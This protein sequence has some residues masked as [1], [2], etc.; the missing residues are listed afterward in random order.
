MAI[1]VVVRFFLIKQIDLKG[2]NK[3]NF[4]LLNAALGS[5]TFVWGIGWF[6]F[7]DT[8]DPANYL[9]YQIISLTVLF[10]GMVGYCVSWKSFSFFVL[11]L[12]VPELIF[13]L[14]NY[15]FDFWPIPI[16]SMVAF[17]LAIKMALLFSKSWEKSYSLR[18][19]ND[20][21]IAQLVAEKNASIAANKAK[22]EFIATASHDLRQPMQSINI[23]IDMIEPQN[24]PESESRVFTRMK[25]SIS[26]LNKMFNTLLDISRLDSGLSVQANKNFSVAQLTHDLELGFAELCLEKNLVLVF[27][28]HDLIAT[29]DPQLVEQILRNLL[30]NAVQYTETGSIV[31]NFENDHG[32]LK[33]SVQDTGHGIPA[34][35]LPVIFN[36]FYRSEHSRSHHDGLGL[37]LSIV[38]RIVQKIGGKCHVI[39]TLGLGS[40]F[41]IHTQYPV[42]Q[43]V[44]PLHKE[45]HSSMTSTAHETENLDVAATDTGQ[46]NI[47]IIENDLSLQT[48]YEQYFTKAGYAVHLIPYEED[49]FN[50]YLAEIPNLHFILSD[51]RLGKHD[52]VFFIQK[53]REEFNEDIP[54]CIVTAD[55]SPQHLELF[56]QL[57]IHVLYKP[58]DIQK[59]EQYIASSLD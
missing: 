24:L 37:G 52:G 16:G 50:Q 26:V 17:Y 18:L 47:G 14:F 27:N 12:K 9:I 3:T 29:G 48:A 15:K 7:V 22:S 38:N 8:A 32:H 11:P 34:D 55:T 44:R 53:L 46:K 10:V 23:F 19:Q 59:I 31:V 2:N 58:I 21:M 57:N 51:Y 6:I 4:R 43:E 1:V 36:E 30:A 35:D 13:I 45:S 56:D 41:T 42:S 54:A 40:I 33:F 20:E 49:E 25:S 5:V 39:S 28:H